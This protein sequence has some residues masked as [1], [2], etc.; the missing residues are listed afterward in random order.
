M[1]LASEE[2]TDQ[3]GQLMARAGELQKEVAAGNRAATDIKAELDGE[4]K[5]RL[6]ELHG[7]A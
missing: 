3:I 6:N 1:A 4:I 7:R 5:P 2:L